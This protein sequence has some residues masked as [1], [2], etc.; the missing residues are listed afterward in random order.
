MPPSLPDYDSV[1]GGSS[2]EPSP[3][4]AKAECA[5]IGADCLLT[6]IGMDD[7]D[8]PYP[9]QKVAKCNTCLHTSDS[10]NFMY[11]KVDSK[12]GKKKYRP[13][14]RDS[15]TTAAPEGFTCMPC[16]CTAAMAEKGKKHIKC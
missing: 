15:R 11:R 2:E 12:S 13:W 6:L 7:P 10:L 4:K 16:L 3:L 8:M 1:C 5:S 14:A 9:H